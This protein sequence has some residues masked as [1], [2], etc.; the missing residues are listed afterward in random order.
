MFRSTILSVSVEVLFV[1]WTQTLIR[2]QVIGNIKFIPEYVLEQ[3]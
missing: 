1:I 2:K 3:I